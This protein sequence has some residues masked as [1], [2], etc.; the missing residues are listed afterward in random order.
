MFLSASSWGARGVCTCIL[1]VF[2]LFR[3][4]G[5]A[6]TFSTLFPHFSLRFYVS[7]A[8]RVLLHFPPS[9]RTPPHTHIIRSE[10]CLYLSQ[11][12]NTNTHFSAK[13]RPIWGDMQ[14]NNCHRKGS[15]FCAQ[16][17][18]ACRHGN[19]RGQHSHRAE[20]FVHPI[21]SG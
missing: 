9:Q 14:R 2:Y 13:F 20:I 10:V 12:I 8:S 3:C 4:V 5:P 6:A 15:S 18:A 7:K 17:S 19:Q 16:R 11:Q 1:I 21:R